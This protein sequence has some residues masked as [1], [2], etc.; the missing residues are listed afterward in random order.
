MVLKNLLESIQQEGRLGY[1]MNI[2]RAVPSYMSYANVTSVTLT[3]PPV[4]IPSNHMPQ[5]LNHYN[6]PAK[7]SMSISIPFASLSIAR[8][9]G[10]FFVTNN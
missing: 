4:V 6:H 5:Q 1:S 9:S 8:P 10:M 7:D 2:D 3:A